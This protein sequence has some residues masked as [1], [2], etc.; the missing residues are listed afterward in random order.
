[1]IKTSSV[2]IATTPNAIKY[3]I[4]FTSLGLETTGAWMA[5]AVAS[6][7]MRL[8]LKID[9]AFRLYRNMTRAGSRRTHRF[10]ESTALIEIFIRR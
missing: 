3:L 1:M 8:A 10:P 4:L 5:P 9:I 7:T 6:T 2:I